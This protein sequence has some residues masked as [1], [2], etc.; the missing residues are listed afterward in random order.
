MANNNLLIKGARII[1]KNFEGVG[2]DYNSPGDRNF[3]V[4]IDKKLADTLAAEGWN[5]KVSKPH[6][7]DPDYE[8][9]FFIKVKLSYRDKKTGQL[10]RYP[11][12]LYM[13]N[14]TGKHL[15]DENTVK[16]LDKKRIVN[17]DLLIYP[18]SYE[19]RQTHDTRIQGY[20]KEL[21]ATIEESEL[22]REYSSYDGPSVDLPFEPD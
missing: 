21:Y 12:E 22:E 15:L 5:V 17:A 14:S 7:E 1:Y 18:W 13:I 16:V 9:Y 10:K 2:T 4:I 3:C 20:V 11:P 19:N 8:P 6:P